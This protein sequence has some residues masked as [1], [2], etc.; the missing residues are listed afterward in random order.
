MTPREYWALYVEQNG[1]PAGVARKLDIPLSTIAA[2]CNG[3]RG[4]GRAL[5]GRMCKADPLLDAKTLIWVAHEKP[6]PKEMPEG[7]HA[8]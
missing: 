5:A 2:V 1:G 6:L 3:S 4:I 7:M 8:G